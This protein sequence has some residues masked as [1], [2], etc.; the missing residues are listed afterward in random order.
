MRRSDET[1]AVGQTLELIF[2]GM[3]QLS[4]EPVKCSSNRRSEDLLMQKKIAR[5]EAVSRE[6]E[7]GLQTDCISLSISLYLFCSM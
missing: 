4:F 3:S 2:E 1:N 5:R 6:S 7:H